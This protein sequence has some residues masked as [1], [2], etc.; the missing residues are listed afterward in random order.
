LEIDHLYADPHLVVYSNLNL[1][2]IT[3]YYPSHT[4]RMCCEAHPAGYGP[5]ELKAMMGVAHSCEKEIMIGT[6]SGRRDRECREESW[7]GSSAGN[8]RAITDAGYS[9]SKYDGSFK[10]VS[11][12]RKIICKFDDLRDLINDEA[13]TR[14]TQHRQL[15]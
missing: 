11:V 9:T 4:S 5:E 15:S 2:I 1:E 8:L 6:E 3:G 12:L 7:K 10:P 14:G 13:V